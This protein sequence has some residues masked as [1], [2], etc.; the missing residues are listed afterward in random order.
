VTARDLVVIGA[1]EHAGVVVDAART[2]SHAWR[3]V[4][5]TDPRSETDTAHRLGLDNLGS[6]DALAERLA[7]GSPPPDDGP[8]LVLGF[9][10]RVAAREAAVGRF[11]TDAQW[12]T[13]V[14][15]AA[16]VSPTATLGAGSVVLAGAVVN[17]GASV[18]CHAI[19]NSRAVIE[20]DVRVG[21]HAHVG[22]G[23]IIGGGARIGDGAFVGLGALVRDHVEVGSGST[24][25]MGAVVVG[26]VPPGVVVTGSPA[27]PR[28][29]GHE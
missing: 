2:Q 20:H 22:P 17:A 9:G 29:G 21:D 10:G 5:F 23:A 1:G 16:W 25:G 6:D 11:G 3:I 4:G 12:A 27:R 18:G 14:H 24:V 26:D 28:D 8:W 19:V 15:A 13:I 7:A